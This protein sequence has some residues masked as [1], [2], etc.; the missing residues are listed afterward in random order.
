MKKQITIIFIIITVFAL[1][2]CSTNTT[3]ET[4]LI[5][6]KDYPNFKTASILNYAGLNYVGENRFDMTLI[7][8]EFVNE[9]M[10]N[11][12]GEKQ[13]FNTDGSLYETTQYDFLVDKNNVVFH[14]NHTVELD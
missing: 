2:A 5:S 7:S 6:S 3:Q 4:K 14:T 13:I 9:H 11:I 1:T 8:W 12:K 10:I